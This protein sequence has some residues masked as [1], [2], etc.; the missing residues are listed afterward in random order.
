MSETAWYICV[1]ETWTEVTCPM[2]PLR[3]RASREAWLG[4][5]AYCSATWTSPL[6]PTAAHRLRSPSRSD[7]GGVSHRIG[8]PSSTAARVTSGVTSHGTALTTKS[9]YAAATSSARE[10]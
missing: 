2:A 9:G 6:A 5:S 8:A 7:A 10:A 4:I 1:E 3:A